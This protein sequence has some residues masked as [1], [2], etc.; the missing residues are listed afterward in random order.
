[1]QRSG[2]KYFFDVSG[3]VQDSSDAERRKEL[4]RDMLGDA[5][6]ELA[7]VLQTSGTRYRDEVLIEEVGRDGIGDSEYLPPCC[8]ERNCLFCCLS[9]GGVFN[10]LGSDCDLDV[11]DTLFDGTLH[12]YDDLRPLA[13]SCDCDV[14]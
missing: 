2:I 6:V 7:A 1:M 9:G 10:K 11:G 4:F 5:T 3:D 13:D 12:S 8:G 14:L